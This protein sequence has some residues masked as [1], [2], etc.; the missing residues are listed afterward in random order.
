MVTINVRGS[1]CQVFGL[2]PDVSKDLQ[3][4][5][6]YQPSG[7]E[8]SDSYKEGKWTGYQYCFRN[9]RF[10]IGLLYDVISFLRNKSIDCNIQDFRQLRESIIC[11]KSPNIVLRPYQQEIANDC[12][13]NKCSSIQVATGGGKSLLA[14]EFIRQ[15]AKKTLILVPSIEILYQMRDMIQD[16]I[17]IPVGII[18]NNLYDPK[19]VTVSTWHSLA[20]PTYDYSEF[21]NSIDNLVIDEAQHIAANHLRQ[22]ARSTSSIYR[23]AMSGTL[24]REDNA[25]MEIIAATGPIQAKI[26]YSYLIDRHYLVPPHIKMLRMPAKNYSRYNTYQEIY[27]D[28]VVNNE[29]RNKHL[30]R[31]AQNLIN[32]GRK[33]LIFVSRIPHGEALAEIGGHEFV[34]SSHPDRRFLIDSFKTGDLKCLIST[35]ML[36]E[37]F[38]CPPIDA[39][40]LAAPQKSLIKTIQ[41]I[42]RGLRPFEN[43][44]DCIVVDCIDPVRYL[45]KAFQRRFKFYRS[46]KSFVI[47]KSIETEEQ[48]T[49]NEWGI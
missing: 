29:F 39:L 7:Y 49:L 3:A 37:G 16:Y 18:G 11:N 21:L 40:V 30:V 32:E 17:Q 8:F 4:K 38:D 22:I 27:E 1:L 23:L 13:H 44:K 6:S 47:E 31:Q 41:R 20:S 43:K 12:F 5:F 25:D 9:N 36:D 24:F 48:T 35:N 15:V 14:A 33:V 26:D 34:Y 2:E 46:E 10:S 28:Y 45:H 19:D 42:G